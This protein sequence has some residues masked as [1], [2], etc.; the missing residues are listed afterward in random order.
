MPIRILW[1]NRDPSKDNSPEL[2]G[3]GEGIEPIFGGG[4]RNVSEEDWWS[5]DGIVGTQPPPD[6]M[7]KIQNCKIFVKSAVGFDDVDVDVWTGRNIPV[8]NC[9]DYGTLEVADHTMALLLTLVKGIAYHDQVLRAQPDLNWHMTSH[10][11]GRRLSGCTMGLVGLGRIAIAVALRA[12]AFEMDVTFFDA[13]RPSGIENSL[14]IRR[15]DTLED[16]VGES[17]IVSIHTPLNANTQ[18]MFN[19]K[20]F[21]SMKTGCIL[22]NTARGAIIDIDDL[23]HAMKEDVV[24]AAGLDVLPEEKP[25]KVDRPLIQAWLANEEWIKHRLVVT[26]HTAYITPESILDVRRLSA[27]TAARYLRD[28]RLENCVNLN[29]ISPLET[30]F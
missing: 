25:M 11:F 9:P 8:C 26:P 13:N 18:G 19:S 12:K 5:C 17:D 10:P 28:G 21:E 16:L 24:L 30:G 2:E 7:K 29:R 15:S 14:G 4:M 1:P 3:M 20:L 6:I 27:R 23:Y 22:I